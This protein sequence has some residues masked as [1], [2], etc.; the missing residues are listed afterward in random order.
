VIGQHQAT[1]LALQYAV[2]CQFRIERIAGDDQAH[3][4]DAKQATRP[5]TDDPVARALIERRK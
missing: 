4:A 3:A 1:R 2:A 5:R